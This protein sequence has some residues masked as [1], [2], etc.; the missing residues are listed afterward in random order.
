MSSTFLELLDVMLLNAV[1]GWAVAWVLGH[2]QG[3]EGGLHWFLV[4]IKEYGFLEGL[5]VIAKAGMFCD[6]SVMLCS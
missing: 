1:I 3:V 2:R 5:P 6:C 4:M